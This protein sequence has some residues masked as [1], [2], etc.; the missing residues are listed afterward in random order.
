MWKPWIW[1]AGIIN[2]K[3]SGPSEEDWVAAQTQSQP[4]LI[5][6]QSL[7]GSTLTHSILHLLKPSV[8]MSQAQRFTFGEER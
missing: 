8:G 3:L 1:R 6:W 2:P 5:A 7:F 4:Y